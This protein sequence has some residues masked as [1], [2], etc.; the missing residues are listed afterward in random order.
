MEWGFA[1]KYV[2]FYMHANIWQAFCCISVV[3]T[4]VERICFTCPTFLND[5]YLE[6]MR[7]LWS[8]GYS[9][10]QSGRGRCLGGTTKIRNDKKD[11]DICGVGLEYK[12]IM[13]FYG[14]NKE[15]TIHNDSQ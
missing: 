11:W 13:Q 10:N 6:W 3:N 4:K 12:R 14:Y 5:C 7:I 8:N 1:S 15:N 2:Y 9:G